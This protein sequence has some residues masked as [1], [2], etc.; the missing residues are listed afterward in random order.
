MVDSRTYAFEESRPEI[1]ADASVSRDA[2]VVGD[3]TVAA[4]ASVWPGVVLRGDVE[5]VRIGRGTHVGDNATLHASAVA[6][7]VM[8]GHG[9][10]LNE[11]TV[12][13]GALVGFNATVNADAT[14]GA[15]SIVA[16]GTV[17]PD[18]YEVPPESFVRGVPA[19]VTPLEETGIDPETVFEE[20]SSGEY[21][22]LAQRHGELFDGEGG[23][24]GDGSSRETGG[25]HD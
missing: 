6:D 22:N 18:G 17:V 24:S 11:A 16:A 20:Y 14:I 1:H 8:I 3:V 21:T 9:A 5:P 2:V 7:R 25:R 15:G 19:E 13:E 4:D 12:E 23:R 10:V